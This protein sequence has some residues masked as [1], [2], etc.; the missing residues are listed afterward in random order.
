M[1]RFI[2]VLLARRN[3]MTTYTQNGITYQ[4]NHITG[5]ATPVNANKPYFNP[6]IIDSRYLAANPRII[7]R[8]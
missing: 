8:N 7:A 5:E 2:L 6:E 3:I 4:I 1:K